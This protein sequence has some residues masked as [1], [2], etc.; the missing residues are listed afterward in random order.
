[1]LRLKCINDLL[2]IYINFHNKKFQKIADVR[3]GD[4]GSLNPDTCGLGGRGVEKSGNFAD[5]LYG[6]PLMPIR[7]NNARTKQLDCNY[8]IL[9]SKLMHALLK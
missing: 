7:A 4:G 9:L 8:Y 6:C 5:V 1:M 2:N 3:G